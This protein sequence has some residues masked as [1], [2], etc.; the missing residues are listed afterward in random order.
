[1][2]RHFTVSFF[3]ATSCDNVKSFSNSGVIWIWSLAGYIL[4]TWESCSHLQDMSIRWL[5]RAPLIASGICRGSPWSWWSTKKKGALVTAIIYMLW[6]LFCKYE[7]DL[8]LDIVPSSVIT[9]RSWYLLIHSSC[10][11]SHCKNDLEYAS[12][13]RSWKDNPKRHAQARYEHSDSLQSFWT[14]TCPSLPRDRYTLQQVKQVP[15]FLY[16]RFPRIDPY[17]Q[18]SYLSTHSTC[19]MLFGVVIPG[20]FNIYGLINASG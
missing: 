5:L 11:L 20:E 4:Q 6:R 18:D 9:R 19:H 3:N 16:N 1:M 13:S 17:P 8:K 10:S 12:R 14:V 2:F 15:F 7:S